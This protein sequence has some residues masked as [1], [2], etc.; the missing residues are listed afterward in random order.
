MD[1]LII[2]G[3]IITEKEANHIPF[4]LDQAF[5]LSQKMWFGFGGIPLL[6][7]NIQSLLRQ[8]KTLNIEIPK[9]LKKLYAVPISEREASTPRFAKNQP[10]H[11]R[12]HARF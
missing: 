6:N 12:F 7:E 2:N 8:L 5:I 9:F 4:F 11:P 3:D 1:F 10:T